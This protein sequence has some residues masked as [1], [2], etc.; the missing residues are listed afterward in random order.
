[1]LENINNVFSRIKNIQKG[2]RTLNNYK[3]EAVKEFESM[4]KEAL[5]KNNKK[6]YNK[7]KN[8]HPYIKNN[9]SKKMIKPNKKN[10][11]K[12]MIEDAINIASVK[13]KISED[14]IKAVIKTESNYDQYGVSKAGAM[15]LMQLMPKTTL[16][17]GVEKPFDIYQNIDGGVRYLKLMLD[18]YNGDLEKA[19]AAYNAG[20]HNV[21]KAS[22]IPDI[23]ETKEYVYLI[24]KLLFK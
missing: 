3:P 21:D 5:S 7:T 24:K 13:Y 6:K 9:I 11:K 17:L 19:L 14:L 2:A 12:A 10:N 20:P 1:M 15:G 22:G 18:R 23:K 4:Y 8:I 16:E